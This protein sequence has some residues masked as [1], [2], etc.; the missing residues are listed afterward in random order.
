M[1]MMRV[2]NDRMHRA[3]L[4]MEAVALEKKSQGEARQEEKD[5]H[6]VMGS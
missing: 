1:V 4:H 6:E 3:R 2:M 5:P